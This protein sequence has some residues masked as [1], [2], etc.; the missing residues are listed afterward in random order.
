[1]RTG[2]RSGRARLDTATGHI[3]AGPGMARA[4]FASPHDS[5]RVGDPASSGFSSAGRGGIVGT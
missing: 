5:I 1:M 4:S 3:E 2:H